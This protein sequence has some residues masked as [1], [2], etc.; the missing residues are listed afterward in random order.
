MTK[1]DKKNRKIRRN[2]SNAKF[3]DFISWL[4]D[5]GFTLDRIRGSHHI[6]VHPVIETPVNAQKMKDGTAKTYQVKQAIKII[7]GE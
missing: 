7:D 5:N 2:P 4:D 1:I 3:Q 6:F